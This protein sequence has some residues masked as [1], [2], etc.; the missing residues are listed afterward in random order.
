MDKEE[1][2][3]AYCNGCVKYYGRQCSAFTHLYPLWGQGECFGRVTEPAEWK[4]TLKEMIN[5]REEKNGRGPS[6]DIAEE[7]K[8]M[9]ILAR[10][11]AYEDLDEV[12]LESLKRGE[13]GGGGEKADR[14]NKTFGPQTMKDNKFMHRKRN[15]GKYRDI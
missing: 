13:G 5:Y 12:Y 6:N 14:T 15:P 7:L 8:R 10:E 3:R 2:A 4:N 11:R 1:K 9:E